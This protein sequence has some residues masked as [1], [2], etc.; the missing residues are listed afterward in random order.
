LG[1]GLQGVQSRLDKL[2][3][4]DSPAYQRLFVNKNNKSNDNDNNHKNVDKESL[5]PSIEILR[6]I[7]WDPSLS[8]SDFFVT[9]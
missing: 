8:S 3:D 9:E 5:T 1:R 7:R 2:K 6:R 4:V